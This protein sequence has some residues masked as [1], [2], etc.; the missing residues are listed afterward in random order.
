MAMNSL[1]AEIV[2]GRLVLPEEALALL[3]PGAPLRVIIDTERGT[4]CI[5]AKDPMT[6]SPQTDELMDALADLSE[7]L[8]WDEYSAPASQDTVRKRKNEGSAE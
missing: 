2:D 1:L 8:T 5:F 4:V 7:G 6:V 3:Q